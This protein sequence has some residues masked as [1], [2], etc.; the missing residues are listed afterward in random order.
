MSEPVIVQ[1][2]SNPTTWENPYPAYSA[3]RERSPMIARIPFVL[4]DGSELEAYGWLLLKHAQVYSVLRAH[5]TFSSDF[6]EV[7]NGPP[8]LQLIQDDPLRPRPSRRSVARRFRE[9]TVPP[10]RC[11]AQLIGAMGEGEAD[12]MS[13]L[14]IPLPVRVI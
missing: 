9:S 4:P 14:A 13:G 3:W 6:P 7:P 11:A 12:V 10:A 2:F 5:E 8:R 1:D